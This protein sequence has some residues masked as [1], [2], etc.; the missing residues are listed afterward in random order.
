MYLLSIDKRTIPKSPEITIKKVVP[1]NDTTPTLT[2]DYIKI[3]SPT[4][5]LVLQFLVLHW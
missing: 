1:K 4:Q 3:N 2:S 5:K